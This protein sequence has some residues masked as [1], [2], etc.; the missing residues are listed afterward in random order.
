MEPH[1]L[2]SKLTQLSK[3]YISIQT[4]F[5][6]KTISSRYQDLSNPFILF[7]LDIENAFYSLPSPLRRIINNDFFYQAYYQWWK[8][9]YSEEQYKRLRAIAIVRFMEAYHAI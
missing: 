2:E 9:I 8:E 1:I 5:Q 7:C 3:N 6:T 4:A